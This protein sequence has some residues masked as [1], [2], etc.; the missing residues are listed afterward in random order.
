MSQITKDKNTNVL[1]LA[2]SIFPNNKQMRE[3]I[4]TYNRSGQIREY[5]GIYQLDPVPKML[6]DIL[7]KNG[8]H[9][10]KIVMLCTDRT[11]KEETVTVTYLNK[12]KR[13]TI[14]DTP[15]SFFKK[16]IK[17][18]INTDTKVEFI[19]IRINENDIEKGISDTIWKL[20][21][22]PNM[23]L[24]IDTH[25]GFREVSFIAEAVISLLKV[26]NIETPKIYGVR[27][28]NETG[29][30]VD[31]SDGF[32]MFDFVSGINEFI[33]YGRVDSLERFLKKH[34]TD[35]IQRER[36]GV[37]LEYIRKVAEG[38]QLCDIPK[39]ENALK[40]LSVFF[41]ENN[42]ILQER[43]DNSYLALFM[44]NMQKDY[45]RLLSS[46]RTVIDEI[47]WCNRKGF[48]Q[49]VLTL[50]EGK[51][52]MALHN[53]GILFY[54]E[55]LASK[56][57]E[58]SKDAYEVNNY[59]FNNSIPALYIPR[60][61]RIKILCGEEQKFEKTEQELIEHL[62]NGV[63]VSVKNAK[64][65]Y[66]S[67]KF[68]VD[69]FESL[70]KFLKLHMGL[71]ELRNHSNH[72]SSSTIKVSLKQVKEAINSYIDLY[73]NL[74]P[75][76]DRE[77]IQVLLEKE[78][79]Q[80]QEKLKPEKAKILLRKI[81]SEMAKDI[82]YQINGELKKECGEVAILDSIENFRKELKYLQKKGEFSKKNKDYYDWKKSSPMI[83]EILNQWIQMDS[84][85]VQ[86]DDD[87]YIDYTKK[88]KKKEGYER[89]LGW[90]SGCGVNKVV[91]IFM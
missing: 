75:A 23:K 25:G 81:L 22:I 77:C 36:Q 4:F 13:E 5:T 70:H 80:I 46:E 39:F 30:I 17:N 3:T 85:H 40:E 8:E 20:R 90:A 26:E 63:S 32:H 35:A 34:E 83:I 49:Q 86:P 91:S 54:N 57:L 37:L 84:H 12:E 73:K 66:G 67:V 55:F 41:E 29:Q 61:E 33:N 68:N 44:D 82:D 56:A 87:L 51:I 79:E 50:L 31:G 19:R 1:L 72:A 15:E 2:L 47:E 88:K 59:I 74:N 21:D 38:I 24:Y 27:Y 78:A 89:I 6:A 18:S 16:Q 45:G 10:D 14:T 53:R 28:G 7:R 71:K 11:L 52:A 64:V 58:D 62:Q 60:D 9:L 42:K 48:Y 43:E 69:D 76:K 65:D